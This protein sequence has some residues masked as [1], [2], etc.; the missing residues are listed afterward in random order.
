MTSVGTY[1]QLGG[2]A[3]GR[4]EQAA[5]GLAET[6]LNLVGRKRQDR[7]HR[8][9]GQEVE[10]EYPAGR[11]SHLAGNDSDGHEDQEEVEVR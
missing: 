6:F 10:A 9:D 7:S 2:I 4:V 1:D 8:Y 11:P 5:K 3:K